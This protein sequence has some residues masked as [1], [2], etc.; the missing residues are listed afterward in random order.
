MVEVGTLKVKDLMVTNVICVTAPGS[1]QDVLRLMKEKGVSGMPVVRKGTRKL[2]GMIT[3]TD[4]INKL[5]EDQVALIMTRDPIRVSPDD[6]VVKAAEL[7]VKHDIR[8]LPVVVGD[9]LV[10]IVTVSDIVHKA[11]ANS[12]I[13]DPVANYMDRQVLTIW[14][15]TPL[16]VA[17]S[18]MKFAGVRALLVLDSSSNLSG[19]LTD[20]DLMKISEIVFRERVSSSRTVSEG[21]EWDWDVSTMIYIG[22]RELS[23]PN[24]PVSEAMTKKLITA[25]EFMPL[26]ECARRM[27]EHG[28][29]QLPVLDLEGR[30]VGIVYDHALLRSLLR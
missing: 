29:D 20:T 18:I 26:N 22:R 15:G 14:E 1:R 2:V 27:R 6:L 12:N 21:Q 4:L 9:E 8:R 5:T 28:I 13:K 17:L 11:L 7:M 16:P 19:I 23:L 24:R 3:R 30:L 10:G 25:L